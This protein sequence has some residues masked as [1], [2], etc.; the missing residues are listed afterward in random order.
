[1]TVRNSK[2]V[3]KTFPTMMD[4]LE[5]RVMLSGN[6]TAT[7]VSG[8]LVIR[9]DA[10]A[11][12]IVMNHSG[13]G[14]NQVRISGLDATTINGAAGPLVI[15]GVRGLNSKMG[16]GNY[17]LKIDDVTVDRAMVIGGGSGND[18]VQIDASGSRSGPRTVV[19]GSTSILMGDGMDI[20]QLGI[21]G[22][23]G[24]QVIFQGRTRL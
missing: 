21:K 24:N 6:V 17:N 11:N 15:G 20:L 12:S 16:A 1:M 7:V 22:N 10:A 14:R 4:T 18:V 2:N 13:L 8:N 5:G 9:G 23:R 19:R 3:E